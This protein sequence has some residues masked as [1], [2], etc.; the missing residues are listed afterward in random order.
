MIKD[1]YREETNR[2]VYDN[3][4]R[5]TY[6]DDYVRWLENKLQLLQTGVMP[7]CSTCKHWIDNFY[8]LEGYPENYKIC[9]IADE[10]KSNGMIDAICSGEGIGG[11]LITRNDFG[12]VLHNEA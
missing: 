12:C 10:D 2:D 4:E 7:S 9:N 3:S 5:G 1:D 8:V 11:E 6:C